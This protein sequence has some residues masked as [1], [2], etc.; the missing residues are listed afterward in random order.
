[1]YSKFIIL[2][3]ILG[4]F[5]I[6]LN[7]QTFS[8]WFSQKKTQKKYLIQQIAAFEAYKGVLA[9]GYEIARN[10][11]TTFWDIRHG[12]FDLHNDVFNRLL[13][14]NPKIRDYARITEILSMQVEI[15]KI[16]KKC[17]GNI[18]ESGVF[19]EQEMSYVSSVFA[20]LL[21]DCAG[22]VDELADLSSASR[23]SMSDEE[24][25]KRLDDLYLSMQENKQFANYFSGETG[26]LATGRANELRSVKKMEKLYE[27]NK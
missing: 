21:E 13:G 26:L 23:L 6:S 5:S 12:E 4:L 9:K 15:L 24:R 20:K 27:N 1:M 14:L 7:A 25:L 10:G 2:A 11:L 22:L 3:A 8:E 18:K 17:L 16:H 19:N